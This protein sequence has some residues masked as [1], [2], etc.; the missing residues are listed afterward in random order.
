[1][2]S[3]LRVAETRNFK[4]R[5]AGRRV[6]LCFCAI[7]P[8][9]YSLNLVLLATR[10]LDP[11]N[12]ADAAIQDVSGTRGEHNVIVLPTHTPI[13]GAIYF[14]ESQGQPSLT[15]RSLCSIEAACRHHPSAR[16]V[17]AMLS[18][19]LVLSEPLQKLKQIVT[20]FDFVH[21]DLEQ[22]LRDSIMDSPKG[23]KLL[24]ALSRSSYKVEHIHF[25]NKN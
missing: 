3:E 14:L 25:L 2:Q 23:R 19:T 8:L 1:M 15:L 22:W 9:L 5:R 20:N 11:R 13:D 4:M 24:R 17:I 7:A 10:R 12:R 16:I 18:S 6:I 21:L